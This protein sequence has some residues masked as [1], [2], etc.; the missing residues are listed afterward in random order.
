VIL[1]FHD[2]NCY[3][4]SYS[5]D[6]IRG[7]LI[8]AVKES[9]RETTVRPVNVPPWNSAGFNWFKRARWTDFPNVV[10]MSL[11]VRCCTSVTIGVMDQ[12]GVDA[13]EMSTL[14]DVDALRRGRLSRPRQ[15]LSNHLTTPWC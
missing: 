10:W 4:G 2:W 14:C 7:G 6:T 5:Q 3:T 1:L 12:K 9:A 8:T 15:W 13:T 11:N